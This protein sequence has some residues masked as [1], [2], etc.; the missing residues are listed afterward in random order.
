M[1]PSIPNFIYTTVSQWIPH[2]ILKKDLTLSPSKNIR[3]SLKTHC[4]LDL[5]LEQKVLYIISVFRT[6]MSIRL[7]S[8]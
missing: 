6:L 1:N 4:I 3:M 8:I 5:I 7:C 2:C